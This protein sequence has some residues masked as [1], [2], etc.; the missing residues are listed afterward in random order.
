MIGRFL[1]VR[2]LLLHENIS[3]FIFHARRLGG[4]YQRF[5]RRMIRTTRADVAI[6]VARLSVPYL[7]TCLASFAI[8]IRLVGKCGKLLR[9]DPIRS[10]RARQIILGY[11]LV[12]TESV[13]A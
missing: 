9:F 10:L 1:I 11:N 3:H 7:V 12:I 6:L 5:A 8:Q 2:A 4:S 13:R